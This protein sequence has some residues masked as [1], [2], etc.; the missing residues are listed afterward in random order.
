M[1]FRLVKDPTDTQAELLALSSVA[2]VSGSLLE[3]TAGATTWVL[4]TATS[5]HFTRKAVAIELV[6]SGTAE[7]KAILV[8]DL[9]LW[10]ADATNSSD[11]AD[12]GD[13]MIL[14]DSVTVNNTGT[15]VSGQKP[16]FVQDGFSGLAAD[17]T[18]IGR[19]IT[20]TGIDPDSS[21]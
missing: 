2:T 18:I 17:N 14:T 13:R 10:E 1:A 6:A 15:D 8:N 12:D 5:D 21:G 16:A 3:R 11:A 20:G 19:I 9:Q 4:C 7:V